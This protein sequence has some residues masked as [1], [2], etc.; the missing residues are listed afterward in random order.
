MGTD[1]TL[2]CECDAF[3]ATIRDVD[4]PKANHV[5][6][7]CADCRAYA[8]H[9]GQETRILDMQG[10]T[11]I[12]QVQPHQIEFVQGAD[13]LAVVRMTRKGP[14]RWY[15]A[16]CDTPV[17]NT[18]GT[19]KLPFAGV[20]VAA[21]DAAP[22]ALGPVRFRHKPEQATGPVPDAPHGIPRLI[23]R[24]VAGMVRGRWSGRWRETPF[25]DVETGLAIAKPC[26]LT[27]AERAAAY[28]T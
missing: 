11:D 24:N 21:T 10:G 14:F 17:F 23:L 16:C 2:R 28:D 9:L 15:A 13:R 1:I 27:E 20:I 5:V 3:V 18:L 22:D 6:C 8:R 19:P 26:T 12:V 25:F 4:D 7:Y